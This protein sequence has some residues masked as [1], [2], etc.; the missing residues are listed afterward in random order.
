MEGWISLYREIREHW[1]W[2]RE[3]YFRAWI[4]ILL[5]VNHKEN[6]VT[7]DGKL[8]TILRGTRYTSLR[9]LSNRWNWSTTKTNKFLKLLEADNMI[10]LKKDNKKTVISVV[11]YNVY[12]DNL[13]KK[14][15]QK[16][17]KSNTEVTQK[18]TNNNEDNENNE[19]TNKELDFFESI[20]KLYPLKK[21]KATIVNSKVK[22]ETI[23]KLNNEMERCIDRYKKY[24]AY[25]RNNGFKNMNYM[26]GSTFF[27]SGYL[28]YLDENYENED[29]INEQSISKPKTFEELTIVEGY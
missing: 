12:Q 27:N 28:D 11:N 26:N 13:N 4:D 16:K 19:N 29:E 3:D 18:K 9:K 7:F 8:I 21:G 15:T 1:I 20:W 6:K 2:E 23:Y 10:I 24:V 14:V 5:M 17:H 25:K 22:L